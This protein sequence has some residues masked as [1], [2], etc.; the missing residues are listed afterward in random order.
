MRHIG[1]SRKQ[2]ARNQMTPG[3]IIKALPINTCTNL[4]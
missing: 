1:L 2:K 4:I 3:F